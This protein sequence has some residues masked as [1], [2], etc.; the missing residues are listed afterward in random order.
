MPKNFPLPNG[1]PLPPYAPPL[2]PFI[3]RPPMYFPKKNYP[4]FDGPKQTD[5]IKPS[6]FTMKG[7]NEKIKE[8]KNSEEKEKGKKNINDIVVFRRVEDVPPAAEAFL[9]VHAVS[10]VIIFNLLINKKSKWI[11]YFIY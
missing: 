8:K 4:K 7:G 5:I 6:A 1:L 9:T 3:Y 2:F 11:N 10:Q